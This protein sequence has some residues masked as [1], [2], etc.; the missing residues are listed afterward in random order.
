MKI[1]TSLVSAVLGLC[2]TGAQAHFPWQNGQPSLPSVPSGFPTWEHPTPPHP[3]GTG[4]WAPGPHK[5]FPTGFSHSWRTN[6]PIPTGFPRFPFP[7]DFP[8]SFGSHGAPGGSPT[9]TGT[10]SFARPTGFPWALP[11]KSCAADAD[12]ADLEC[13][14]VVPNEG[15]HCVQARVGKFCACFAHGTD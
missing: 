1:S 9:I 15:S 7:P 5:P 14:V 10:G 6:F 3:T 2:L 12:C 8:H 4:A 13:P 11:H